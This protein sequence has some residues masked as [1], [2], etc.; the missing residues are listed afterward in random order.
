VVEV[1]VVLDCEQPFFCQKI[2]GQELKTSE[3][4]S[5]TVSAAT[6]GMASPLA[7]HAH[8]HAR[9]LTCFA[10]F[11]TDFRAKQR[12]LAV[13]GCVELEVAIFQKGTG[14][15]GGGGGGGGEC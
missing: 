15:G 4:A 6:S 3:R 7:C 10:F 9:T 8:S 5:V 13:Y 14:A 1:S 2:R 11:L 12:L